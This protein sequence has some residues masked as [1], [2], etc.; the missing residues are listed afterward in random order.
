M[1]LPGHSLLY[2]YT[3]AAAAVDG[4][5]PTGQ[6]RLGLFEFTNDP[7]ESKQWRL[8]AS[9]ADRVD[10]EPGAL[11]P[12]SEAADRL[13]RRSVKLACFTEDTPPRNDIDYVSGRGFGHSRLWSHYAA[14]HSGVCI[15]FD[16]AALLA[17]LAEQFEARGANFHGRVNYVE[18]PSPPYAATH[19]DIEQVDEFGIDAV[20]AATVE[21]HWRELFF[22]KDLDWATEHE[23]PWVVLTDDPVPLFVDV[24][25]C[26]RLIVLGDSFP[27]A[28]VPSYATRSG[29]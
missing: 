7:R 27:A 5:L 26:V 6:L 17:A 2:H 25:E 9:V 21:Q 20:I 16:R 14:N 22:T 23:Y 8:S 10:F 12:M 24:S 3:S 18:D 28:R 29:P 11:E 4:I 1:H 19:V 15:G 13:L